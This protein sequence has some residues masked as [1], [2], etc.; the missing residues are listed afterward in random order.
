MPFPS[1][2]MVRRVA[3]AAVVCAAAAAHAADAAPRTTRAELVMGAIARITIP[4]GATNDA[5]EAGFATLRRVD[6]GMSLYRPESALVR[7]NARAAA[8]AERVDDELFALLARAAELSALTDGA[9]DVTILPLLRA[10]GAY[11]GLDHVAAGRVDAVGWRELRLD[12]DA[13]TVAFGRDG[14]G[15]D[16]GGIAKGFALD[17]ARAALAAA[18][19]RRATV[20]LGG[21]LALLGDGPDGAWHIAVR[22]PESADGTLGVLALAAGDT[23]STSGNYARDFTAEGWRTPSHIYDPRTGKPVRG[24]LAVTVWTSDATAADALSTAFLVLGAD[25][26]APVLA[27][28]PDVG[29]LFVDGRTPDRRLTLA[30]RAPLGFAPTTDAPLVTASATITESR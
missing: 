6:A 19:V 18:G 30:G 15:I 29:A 25:A 23:V 5:F 1:I 2:V 27:R 17:R 16:L 13:K 22:D 8:H 11:P 28:F 3:V 20:D 10:W 24:D 12:H 7:V 26:S 14:M 9:F 21:N 4:D